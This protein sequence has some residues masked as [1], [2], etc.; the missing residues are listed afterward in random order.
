[1]YESIYLSIYSIGTYR[2]RSD[3]VLVGQGSKFKSYDNYINNNNN[4]TNNNNN[5]NNNTTSNT[6]N[7]D[8]K[9]RLLQG[10]SIENSTTDFNWE[11]HYGGG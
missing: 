1:M 8:E 10:F 2:R 9:L 7:Q 4:T 6:N 11:D 5:N 3:N